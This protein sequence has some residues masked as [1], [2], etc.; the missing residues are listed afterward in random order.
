MS[1]VDQA[2]ASGA[3]ATSATV[4]PI[5]SFRNIS[6]RWGQAVGVDDVDLDIEARRVLR[7][8]RA[9]GLRQDDLA[10]HVRR[11]SRSADRGPHLYYPA[12]KDVVEFR[13]T[14]AP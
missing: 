4:K 6:K 8:V 3:S 12:A 9:V 13:R 2:A 11:P 5:I 1:I 7:A 14:A 10:A